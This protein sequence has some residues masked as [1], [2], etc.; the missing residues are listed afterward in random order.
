MNQKSIY[1]MLKTISSKIFK[2]VKEISKILPLNN[3]EQNEEI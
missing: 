3:L 2:E 1:I